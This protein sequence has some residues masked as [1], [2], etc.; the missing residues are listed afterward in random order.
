MNE[1]DIEFTT[2]YPGDV[3]KEEKEKRRHQ[4]RM[5]ELYDTVNKN[6]QEAETKKRT[7]STKEKK[8]HKRRRDRENTL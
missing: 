2:P 4:K 8:R 1:E 5:R 7:L 6:L 3:R